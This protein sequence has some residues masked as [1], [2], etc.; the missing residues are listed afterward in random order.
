MSE[1]G[2]GS[3]PP[4]PRP[5]GP[6]RADVCVIGLGGSG[7]SA[8]HRLVEN[9][10]LRVVGLDARTIAAGAAGRNGGFLLAGPAHFH[11]RVRETFG[12]E[13]ARG[14]YELSLEARDR[15][16]HTEPSARAEG[17]LRTAWDD[18]ER[19]DVLA[20]L[21]ALEADGLPGRWDEAAQGLFVPGDATFDPLA[22]CVRMAHAIADRAVLYGQAPVS[23]LEPERAWLEDGTEVRAEVFLVC[24]D[25][26]LERVLP[27]LEAR[28]RSV[29]LQMLGTAPAADVQVR[30]AVYHRFGL[31]YWQQRPDGR[32]LL[33]GG[34]DVGGEA[35]EGGPSGTS[36]EV[37]AHLEQILRERVGT[38]APITHRWSGRVG[39]SKD[40]LPIVEEHLPG[41]FVAGGYSGTGNVLG[42]L[43]GASLAELALG[44]QRPSLLRQLEACRAP[45]A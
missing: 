34:R 2:W 40:G 1:I 37:Q 5:S 9:P 38:R 28:T 14:L 23:E 32:V 20:H 44:R 16:V 31:D 10:S 26:G 43:A 45:S 8:L 41:V 22:R 7:L 17:S 11:H 3:P 27:S 30:G 42:S 18:E 12:P 35:E 6:I 29:R 24:V 13:R 21:A 33:G 15:I 19:A 36:S 39:M 25:G 4:L